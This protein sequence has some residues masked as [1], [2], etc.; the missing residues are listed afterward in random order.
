ML[1][2]QTLEKSV[3]KKYEKYGNS[4]DEI[5]KDYMNLDDTDYRFTLTIQYH[6]TESVMKK[7]RIAKLEREG[8]SLD[9]ETRK[10]TEA[11]AN[12]QLADINYYKTELGAKYG[13]G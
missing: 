2:R 8:F 5:Y 9:E 1:L 7:L 3:T 4:L 6:E 10:Q 13:A 11:G 12:E